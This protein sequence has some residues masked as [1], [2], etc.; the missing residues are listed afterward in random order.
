MDTRQGYMTPPNASEVVEMVEP[1]VVRQLR[2]LAG[3]GWGH[4]RIARELGLARNT[5]RRY[6]RGGPEAETQVRPRARRLDGEATARAKQLFTTEAE[7]NAVVV[8]QE[9]RK[10][11]VEVSVRTVQRAVRDER[12]EKAAAALATVRFE[13]V[14]GRQM[15]VDFGQK[16]VRIGSAV[17]VVHLLVAV[18]SYSRRIFVKAFLAERGDDWREGIALAFQ[19]FGGVPRELLIDNARALVA[20]R[21]RATQTVTLHPQFAAFCRDWGIVPRACAPYRART[22]GKSE[23][24]VKYVKNNGLAGRGFESF[25]ALEAHLLDWMRMADERVHGTTREA[26]RE[27][28]ERDEADALRCLPVRPL[29]SREQRLQRRVSN[30]CFV[31]VDTVHYSVPHRFV[32]DEVE[33]LVRHESVLVF[34]DNRVIAEHERSRE[35]HSVVRDPRHFEGLWRKPASR[36]TSSIETFG[37]SLDDYAFCMGEVLS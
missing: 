13:T 29:P 15:Q 19:H 20:G 31:Q 14:P 27:R 5:V 3:L 21:D 4:K 26:P 28:F 23:S 32:R 18:L 12:L 9:L 25:A 7:G 37:R 2:E 33:V 34:A 6:L 10:D 11:G 22:K 17:V 30:D 36:A 35:P 24:G 16:R 1:E 8:A